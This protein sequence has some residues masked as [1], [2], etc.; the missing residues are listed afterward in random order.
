MV[1]MILRELRVIIRMAKIKLTIT[2]KSARYVSMV[3]AIWFM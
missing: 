1:Y 3:K 2:T